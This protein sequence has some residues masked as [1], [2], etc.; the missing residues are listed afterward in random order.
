MNRI[1]L[2]LILV[3]GILVQAC[4]NEGDKKDQDT[5]TEEIPLYT[6]PEIHFG[7]DSLMKTSSTDTLLL[8]Y[9]FVTK[10]KNKRYVGITTDSF[11][12][13]IIQKYQIDT[14]E[15]EVLFMC[16]DGYSASVKI[17]QLLQDPGFIAFR[18]LD[19]R[20]DW[21]DDIADKFSPYYL[22]WNL[23]KDDHKHAFPYGITHIKFINKKEGFARAFPPHA[24]SEVEKG[25]ELFKENC[26]KCHGINK[27]G[28][29]LGP[30]LNVPK[31]VTEYWKAEHIKKFIKDPS[32]YR[33]NSKMPAMAQLSEKEIEAI[34]QYLK[35]MTA[36]KMIE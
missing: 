19:A 3:C 27:T 11:F 16:K 20:K 35:F 15:M 18:D 29:T 10:K 7:L 21:E 1:W 36:H 5:T 2:A 6:F 34:L 25:F 9:D 31:N 4:K 24:S 33:Y 22:V 14:T 23:A 12:K 28:G 32:Q 30:D 13:K 8:G 17:H 26:I